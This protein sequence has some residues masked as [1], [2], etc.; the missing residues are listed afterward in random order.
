[1]PLK[2]T[3]FYLWLAAMLAL[4]SCGG[5]QQQQATP[6]PSM[7][8]SAATTVTIDAVPTHAPF[9]SKATLNRIVDDVI[10]P[11]HATFS[12]ESR[13]LHLAA[14]TFAAEPNLETLS[15]LQ[16]QWKATAEAWAVMEFLDVRAS[17]VLRRQIKQW[18]PNVDL[19][20]ALIESNEGIVDDFVAGQGSHAKGLASIEYLIFDSGV[21]SN[22]VTDDALLSQLPAQPNRTAYIVSA[23]DALAKAAEE[24]ESLWSADG[25]LAQQFV[26]SKMPH[27]SID[28]TFDQLLNA[29]IVQLDIVERGKV[30]FP[31]RGE[32][33]YAKPEAV[34]S[35]YANHS[36]V[37]IHQNLQGIQAIMDAGLSDYLLSRQSY[38]SSTMLV[39]GVN[40]QHAVALNALDALEQPLALMVVDNPWAVASFWEEVKALSRRYRVDIANHVGLVVTIGQNDGD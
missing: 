6:A 28:N 26:G 23:T 7:S 22:P 34:E 24:L 1:M 33:A 14:K 2:R 15:T 5:D 32:D 17:F 30:G 12:T 21:K 19:I 31:L 39:Q 35:P 4:A 37:L 25:E 29:I 16:K 10:I 36:L 8:Q 20:E 38:Q 18:P 13:A 9:D 27:G 40:D 11:W 3:P